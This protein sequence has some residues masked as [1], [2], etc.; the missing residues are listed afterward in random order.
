MSDPAYKTLVTERRGPVGIIKLNRP[1]R[2]NAID[3]TMVAEIPAA[4]GALDGDEE[5]RAI[6][7]C[8]AGRAF[9]A[10]FDLNEDA[11]EAPEGEAAWRAVL[12]ADFDMIMGFWHARK[13]TIAAV[14]GYA[15]A[16]GFNLAM[17]CDMTVAEEG[18][19]FGEPELKFGSASLVLLMPWLAGPKRAKE[20]LLTGEDRI[21]AEEALAMGMVNRVVPQGQ[22]LSAALELARRI[23]VMDPETVR[24]TKRS[25]NRTYETMGLMQALDMGLETA[26]AIEI[27]QSP[28]RREFSE[29]VRKEGLKAALAWREGRFSDLGD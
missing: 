9:C 22:H 20:F 16:G 26:V 6:V 15:V 24:L 28:E 13:P 12:K 7:L 29:I 8:G 3:K 4:L 27:L 14:H 19:R 23:A 10:G 25:V 17:A 11:A 2:L 18:T 1:G 5:I 21:G